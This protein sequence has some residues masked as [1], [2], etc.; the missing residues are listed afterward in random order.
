MPPIISLND[1]AMSIGKCPIFGDGRFFLLSHSKK[2]D[3]RASR[4]LLRRLKETAP[5][6]KIESLNL[7]QAKEA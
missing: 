4:P 3:K 2:L 7:I 1:A 6:D 5:R